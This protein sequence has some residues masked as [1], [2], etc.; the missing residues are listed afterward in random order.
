MTDGRS[1]YAS[2]TPT[3][4]PEATT[5][6]RK[7]SKCATPGCIIPVSGEETQCAICFCKELDLIEKLR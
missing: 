5:E 3:A 6:Q 4:K 1:F 7:L 2:G